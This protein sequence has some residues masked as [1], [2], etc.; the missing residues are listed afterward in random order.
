MRKRISYWSFWPTHPTPYSY[1]WVKVLVTPFRD[2][3]HN[4]VKL[5]SV[6][7][8]I[9]STSPQVKNYGC[10]TR[11]IWKMTL[12]LIMVE[13]RVLMFLSN[14]CRNSKHLIFVLFWS[15]VIRVSTLCFRISPHWYNV[16]VSSSRSL[17]KISITNWECRKIL[18]PKLSSWLH[19]M[20]C[21]SKEY[22][23]ILSPLS[24]ISSCVKF[25]CLY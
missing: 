25:R 21:H 7:S 2:M 10:G 20:S 9:H 3:M 5:S 6:A 12:N 4:P 16:L 13:K 18:K 19:L 24:R 23:F 1:P 22:D 14:I 8:R 15:Y 17:S 11:R